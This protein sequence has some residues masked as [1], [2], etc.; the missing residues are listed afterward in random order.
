[1]RLFSLYF[2]LLA[3]SPFCTWAIPTLKWGT[4]FGGSN[5][6][7]LAVAK[8]DSGYVYVAG[9]TTS[10]TNIAT[11]GAY[12][13]IYGG[14][15][16]AFLAKFDSSGMLVW[17]TYFGGGSEDQAFGLA[18][19]G[20]G[21][22]YMT[23]LTSSTSGIATAG[24]YQSTYGGGIG[25]A[26]L[27]KFSSGGSLLW[28]TYYGGSGTELA[29]A[30]CTDKTGAAYITGY[31]YST[32]SI[33]TVG[34]YK[35]SGGG[36][37]VDGFIAK[38]SP[39]GSIIWATYYGGNDDDEPVGIAC[40][41]TGNVYMTGATSSTDSISTPGAYQLT[42]QGFADDDGF[43]VK[44]NS[45]GA[46]QW[47]TYYGANGSN[48]VQA[49]ISDGSNVYLTGS[50]SCTDSIASAGSYRD[51]LTG[52]ADAFLVKF[53]G[54]GAM[55]W[56]TYYGNGGDGA[57]SI[58][59]DNT[60]IV[61]ITG[62]TTSAIGIATPGAYQEVNA[63]GG[64]VFVAQFS[65]SGTLLWGSYY[66]GSGYDESFG[67]TCNDNGSLYIAGMTNSTESIATAGAYDTSL[68]AISVNYNAFLA[69][70]GLGANTNSI[71]QMAGTHVSL[72]IYPNPVA[73]EINVFWLGISAPTVSLNIIDLAGRTLYHVT[74]PSSQNNMIIPASL[75]P[76]GT[77]ICVLESNA[78]KCYNRF[79]KASIH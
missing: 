47:G 64:D 40:D 73:D 24:E 42:F 4:Y 10:G 54:A 9:Y 19:D 8:G 37:N 38:F 60:G 67:I 17:A 55:L 25:D 50:T 39:T 79:T 3:C 69:K 35:T 70:F 78:G 46:L 14:N 59:I 56:G 61:S 12:Q 11:A 22:V 16:D 15:N 74:V 77:Y 52:P 72:N 32:D 71:K 45:A 36:E 49:I 30:I 66:G 53:N 68:G 26:F 18:C 62:A 6:R 75:F 51:T 23:G 76:Y 65:N 7:G 34:A 31:T 27:A 41:S 28:A 2:L 29:T 33:A 63:G 58:T 57:N 43:L 13:T 1:M 5:A 48:E 44:F 21:N 20:A